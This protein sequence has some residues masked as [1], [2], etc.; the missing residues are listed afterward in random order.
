MRDTIESGIDATNLEAMSAAVAYQA[1]IRKKID[2]S[3]QLTGYVKHVLDFGAGRGDYAKA[4]QAETRS[5]LICFE[6]DV[7]LHAYYPAHLAVVSSLGQVP[8][9]EGAYSLNVFEHIDDD[10]QALRELARRCRPGSRIFILVPALMSLWTPMDSFVGHRRRYTPNDLRS[11]AKQAN[12]I[13]SGHGWFDRAGYFAT[14]AYQLLHK[15][16]LLGANAG[17]V[18]LR[19]IQIFDLLFRFAE[20]VLCWLPFGKNCWIELTVPD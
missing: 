3:L 15:L 19:Q 12:L 10:A 17:A 16:G 14:K 8:L 7:A 9:V 6:P 18:S 1:A 20:P 5:P 13:V 4:L 11:L 2:K